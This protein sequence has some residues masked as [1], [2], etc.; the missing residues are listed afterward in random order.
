[1]KVKINFGV[2]IGFGLY[3][4]IATTIIG[5]FTNQV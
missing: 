3:M 5:F 2:Y 1:M 4:G